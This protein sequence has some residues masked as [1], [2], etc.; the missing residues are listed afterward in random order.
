[1]NFIL[2]WEFRR[3]FPV[4]KE[5]T[6]GTHKVS[7]TKQD[8]VPVEAILEKDGKIDTPSATRDGADK[9]KTSLAQILRDNGYGDSTLLQT[10]SDIYYPQQDIYGNP[11]QLSQYDPF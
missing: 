3:D 1:M 9:G 6:T 4:G 10:G 5:R 11:L 8:I 2:H 7:L